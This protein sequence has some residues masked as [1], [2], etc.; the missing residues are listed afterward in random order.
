M[1]FSD[2]NTILSNQP[3]KRFRLPLFLRVSSVALILAIIVMG[4][5]G[6]YFWKYHKNVLFEE[7][8]RSAENIL[9]FLALTVKT[10]LLT[11]DSLRMG[12]LVR[13]AGDREGIF[14][15]SVRDRNKN[16]RAH[17]GEDDLKGQKSLLE[18]GEVFRHN[19][20]I[21]IMQYTGP[22]TGRV[23]DLS[24]AV[25]YNNKPLGIVHLRL[26]ENYI[27]KSI[28]ET[29]SSFLQSFLWLSIGI[30][31]ISLLFAA[32]FTLRIKRRNK[33]LL[34]AVAE[35]GDGNLQY[36]IENI[37]NNESGDLAR[38]LHGM[39]EKL[40]LLEPSQARLEQ[41]L[42]TSSLDQ[43]LENST[44]QGT[45]YA[46]RRQ[47]AVLFASIKGFGSFAE[48]GKP[49]NIIKALNKYI[50]I[51]TTIISKHGGYVDKVVGDAMVGIFGVS[52]YH[53]D[54][55]ARVTQAALDLQKALSVGDEQESQLLSNVCVGISSG[56]VLSG[57]IG[58]SSKV[59]YSSIG[60][61]I[62]EAYWLSNLGHL[63]EIL[64]GEEIYCQ[65][66]DRIMVEELPPQNVLG[67]FEAM[68]CYRLLG[69]TEKSNDIKQ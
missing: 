20:G 51:V 13:S 49:E 32:L 59:E 64:L 25:T 18:I 43:I 56:I 5:G 41:Y 15:T 31:L 68:K 29:R 10:P 22:S 27:Q 3:P 17:F 33:R 14:Y 58:P 53:G 50:S 45:P 55:T 48:T 30:M 7:K 35:Y 46:N 57:N 65:L 63:G 19:N 28:E 6:D 9:D 44:T 34:S 4:S 54:H 16:I 39:T 37:E 2:D 8:L 12:I 47:V 66:Q 67:D 69:M 42:Q 52:M 62:K 36:R 21:M 60:E 40:V 61:S 38:A 1:Q 24:K 11:D 23:Y 26:S